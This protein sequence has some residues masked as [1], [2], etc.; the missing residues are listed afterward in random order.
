MRILSEYFLNNQYI[1][2]WVYLKFLKNKFVTLT[3]SV[4][5]KLVIMYIWIVSYNQISYNVYMDCK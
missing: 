4:I 1:G 3:L 2:F 5:T